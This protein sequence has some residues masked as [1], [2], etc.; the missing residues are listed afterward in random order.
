MKNLLDAAAARELLD[1]L[2]KLRTDSTRQWGKMNPAQ[3]M[4]HVAMG[5]ET[6]LGDWKPPRMLIGRILGGFV[7]PM[8]LGDDQP[9]KRN[10]PTVPSMVITDTRA[11]DAERTR[12]RT[13]IDRF[14]AGGPAVCTTHS[15]SFFGRMT[16]D[17]WAV[18]MYKHVDHHLRQFGA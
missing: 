14:V 7:K 13:L 1:R 15:H 8:A 12:V 11:L 2:D 18:L 3:A 10:S 17:E 16:P 6:A 4:A 9:M 5:L